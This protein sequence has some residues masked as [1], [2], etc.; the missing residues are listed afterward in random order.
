MSMM[1]SGLGEVRNEPVARA[2]CAP[3]LGSYSNTFW[4]A[5]PIPTTT[6]AWKIV[7]TE[8]T[9]TFEAR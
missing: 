8:S 1:S 2:S 3:V 7:K 4:R 6:M 9:V 5:R